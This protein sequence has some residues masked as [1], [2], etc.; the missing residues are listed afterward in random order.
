MH[1]R[2]KLKSEGKTKKSIPKV[3]KLWQ[4]AMAAKAQEKP[5]VLRTIDKENGY[6]VLFYS[7]HYLIMSEYSSTVYR[8]IFFFLI[9]CSPKDNK[10][11]HTHTHTFRFTVFQA[12]RYIR[13]IITILTNNNCN[14]HNTQVRY[15]PYKTI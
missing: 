11:T 3:R 6:T 12:E 13:H 7:I 1:I 2:N 5:G 10:H 15:E 14:Q 8:R 4:Q 9:S